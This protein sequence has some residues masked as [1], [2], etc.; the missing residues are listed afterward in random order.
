MHHEDPIK[1]VRFVCRLM[2]KKAEKEYV[3][4]AG[5]IV[6]R[7]FNAMAKMD[8]LKEMKPDPE[9]AEANKLWIIR[10][11]LEIQ[12]M[13]Q[14]PNVGVLARETAIDLLLK[15]LMHMDGGIPRGWSWKFVE[16]RG[17]LALLDVAS[18]I[19]EQCDYPVSSE[20]RQ[21]VA[22]C[23]QRLEEDMVFD[24]KRAIFKDRVDS[25]FK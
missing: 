21:H 3:D 16:D 23:L 25:F 24:T 12:E 13:L 15:N 14:D 11:L 4:A 6:Q 8:R 20:T 18:Q 7:V 10:V 9:V 19:P 17:L 1:S 5:L 22:I 2:C